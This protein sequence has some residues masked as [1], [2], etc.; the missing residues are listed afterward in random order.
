MNLKLLVFSMFL[1]LLFEVKCLDLTSRT[2]ETSSSLPFAFAKTWVFSTR[3]TKQIK[4]KR[5]PLVMPA[6][7]G[8]FRMDPTDN[9]TVCIKDSSGVERM[10]D[11]V[12]MQFNY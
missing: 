11:E 6:C 5:P 9:S 2:D 7:V 12:Y 10:A 8:G 3:P 1:F 4:T